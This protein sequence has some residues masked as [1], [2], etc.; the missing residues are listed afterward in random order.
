[1]A[2][3]MKKENPSECDMFTAPYKNK[4]LPIHRSDEVWKL[5]TAFN[6]QD[7]YYVSNYGK[8]YS[9]FTNLLVAPRFIGRGYLVMTLRTKDNKRIDV[10][11]HR[12]VMM[13]FEPIENAEQ[14]QVNH[15][16]GIKTDNRYSNLE[17][18]TQEENM[19]HAYQI[20]LRKPGEDNNFCLITEEKAKEI[21]RLL[22]LNK[23]TVKEIDKLVDLEGHEPL[24]VQIKLKHNWKHISK[25]Y[26]F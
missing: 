2:R 22:E 19:K 5:A 8:V 10:L 15:K 16:N 9:K 13:T 20:G 12:L 17:W 11:V 21:C 3:T 24:I 14:F 23:Y 25:D 7:W 18:V 6:L 1:M 26:N 4:V